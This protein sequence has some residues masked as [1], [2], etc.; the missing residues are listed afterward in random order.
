MIILFDMAL[1]IFSFSFL[2][3]ENYFTAHTTT[4][5]THMSTQHYFDNTLSVLIIIFLRVYDI[6]YDIPVYLSVL[7]CVGGGV[8]VSS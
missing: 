6:C 2:G 7:P 3:S 5:P 4:D 1:Y 8:R